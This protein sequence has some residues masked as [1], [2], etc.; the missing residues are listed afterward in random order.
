[1]MKIKHKKN[2]LKIFVAFITISLLVFILFKI[3]FN[4]MLETLSSTNLTL[5]IGALLIYLG[6]LII[7]SIRWKVLVSA[8]EIKVPFSK[9]LSFYFAGVFFYFFMPSYLG[10]DVVRIYALSKYSESKIKSIATVFMDRVTGIV[11]LCIFVTFALIFAHSYIDTNLLFILIIVIFFGFTSFLLLLNRNIIKRISFVF[12][13]LFKLFRFVKLE[14]KATRLYEAIHFYKTKKSKILMAIGL[15]LLFHLAGVVAIYLLALA[16]DLPI[17]FQYLI[18]IFPIIGLLILLPITIGGFGVREVSYWYF[19]SQIEI[20]AT[21]TASL[22]VL[23][24]SLKI[25]STLIG[26]AMNL[27]LT[28]KR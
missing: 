23:I 6:G 24:Y 3:D 17:P 4:E 21:E 8:H 1:M 25:I 9:V 11:A 2:I 5:Y 18:L 10:G 27:K 22:L 20:S 19:L 7:C 15:S 28:M 16:L 26:G 14:D 13:P 12:R